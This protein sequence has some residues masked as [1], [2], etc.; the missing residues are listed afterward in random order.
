M[1][2]VEMMLNTKRN[3]RA[4]MKPYT[5]REEPAIHQVTLKQVDLTGFGSDDVAMSLVQSLQQVGFLMPAILYSREPSHFVIDGRKRLQAWQQLYGNKKSFP[6]VIL[7]AEE[8]DYA[9]ALLLRMHLHAQENQSRV[10][11]ELVELSRLLSPQTVPPMADYILAALGSLENPTLWNAIVALAE[12]D[13]G[14]QQ[15]FAER[16]VPLATMPIVAE[17]SPRCQQYLLDYAQ[18]RRPSVSEWRRLAQLLLEIERRGEAIEQL[19]QIF[20]QTNSTKQLVA[21]LEE[22][23]HPQTSRLAHSLRDEWES[24]RMPKQFKLDTA[25][26]REEAAKLTLSFRSP[27][28][29][30]RLL[31][32]LRGR[33]TQVSFRGYIERL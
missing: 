33:L 27:Q 21:A 14:L 31:E 1:C 3:Y 15:E 5:S 16:Q 17:L 8:I 24:F 30:E 26:D 12:I 9:T 11:G 13:S 32:D 23:R 20:T 4:L 10:T 25:V 28:E 2:H 18:P 19:K 22:L 29:L 7:A 6:A